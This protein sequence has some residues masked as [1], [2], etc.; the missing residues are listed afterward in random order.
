MITRGVAAAFTKPGEIETADPQ[1]A[2]VSAIRI[3]DA[4]QKDLVPRS[5]VVVVGTA[6]LEHWR[7]TNRYQI[8]YLEC[9]QPLA[10]RNDQSV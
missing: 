9:A 7:L 8:I 10:T 6:E 3:Q 5:P 4:A 2:T 1:A